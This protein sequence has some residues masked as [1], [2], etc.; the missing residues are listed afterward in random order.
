MMPAMSAFWG[1]PRLKADFLLTGFFLSA[2][3]VFF[4]GGVPGVS[5]FCLDPVPPRVVLAGTS[6]F[7]PL[8]VLRFYSGV[9]VVF[10]SAIKIK[11]RIRSHKAE[12]IVFNL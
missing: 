11:S 6:T 3:V 2:G 5:G 9:G 10:F 7:L 8:V 12:T 4:F 1:S